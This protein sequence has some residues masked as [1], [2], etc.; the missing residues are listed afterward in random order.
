[1]TFRWIHIVLIVI[2]V[3]FFYAST[4][5]TTITLEDAGLF[6]M[7]CHLDGIGHPPGYPLF[8]LLC[9]QMTVLPGVIAGNLISV[10]FALAAVV[11][12]YEV[13]VLITSHELTALLAAMAYALSSAF[14]SQAIIIEVY[15]LAA[16]LFMLAWWLLIKFSQ[17]EDARCWFGL[18]LVTGLGLSNHW[19]LFVLSCLGLMSLLIFVRIHLWALMHNVSFWVGFF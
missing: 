14:W 12:F 9:N 13:V 18:C 4:M 1:M 15:S 17:T 10:V 3:A 7:V 6:Q 5:P 16:C 19:P 8:T 2:V 11:L